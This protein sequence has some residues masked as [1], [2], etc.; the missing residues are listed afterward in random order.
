MKPMTKESPPITRTMSTENK[1]QAT[2]KNPS[3][4]TTS[5]MDQLRQQH[6]PPQSKRRRNEVTITSLSQ[7]SQ[8][9]PDGSDI[10][11]REVEF[12]FEPSSYL[13]PDTNTTTEKDDNSVVTVNIDNINKD[14]SETRV[15]LRIKVPPHSNPEEKLYKSSRN[16]S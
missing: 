4:T 9:T 7:R 10:D 13:Q 15:D 8:S 11:A 12:D 3:K 6:P 2:L 14:L 5:I 1:R 16:F